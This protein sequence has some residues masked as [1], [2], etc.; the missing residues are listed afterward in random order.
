MRLLSATEAREMFAESGRLLRNAEPSPKVVEAWESFALA[1][2]DTAVGAVGWEL[3]GDD[4]H[5]QSM[6][7]LFY[8]ML[9]MVPMEHQ[10]A[11]LEA[12]RKVGVGVPTVYDFR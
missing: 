5:Y 10:M 1:A 2:I 3:G 8:L 6:A 7:R 4:P 11:V 9:T 12:M